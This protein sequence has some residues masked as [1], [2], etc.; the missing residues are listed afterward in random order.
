ME[1]QTSFERL[2]LMI[3]QADTLPCYKV[4]C[5]M[6]IVADASPVGLG[7]VLTQLQGSIWRVIVFASRSL[8]DVERRYSQTEKEALALVWACKRLNIYVSRQHFELETDHKPLK[9]IYSATSNPYARIERWFLRL[10]SYHFKVVYR[11][12]KANIADSHTQDSARSSH[13]DCP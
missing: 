7:P 4:G 13:E 10:Q 3:T 9:R 2:K 6:R 5:R 8:T 11:Q 1:H 12:G